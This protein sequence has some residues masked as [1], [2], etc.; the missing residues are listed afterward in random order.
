MPPFIL[1]VEDHQDLRDMLTTALT[2]HGY[3]IKA[4]ADGSAALL[5]LWRSASTGQV[6]ELILLDL[7]MPG[8]DGY[9]FLE[10]L[11]G[12]WLIWPRPRLVLMT[13]TSRP[14]SL[15]YPVLRKPFS[16]QTL[17]ALLQH[18]LE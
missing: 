14:L 11:K 5:L 15:P 8:M 4:A 3:Q 16:L 17:V 1:I 10:Q 7:E 9:Q 12:P 6:P 13:A 2:L 18:L